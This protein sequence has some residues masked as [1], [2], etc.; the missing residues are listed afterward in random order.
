MSLNASTPWHKKSYDRFLNDSLPRLLA[1]RLP[2][3]GYRSKTAGT[4]E[5]RIV[6]TLSRPDG[7]FEA[8]YLIPQPDPSGVFEIEQGSWVVVPTASCDDLESADI[9]C[10][11]E[12]LYRAI[13]G[14]LGEAPPDFAWDEAL[15]RSW[16]PLD[17]WVRDFLKRSGQWLDRTNWLSHHTHLRRISIPGRERVITRSHFGRTCPIETP[18]GPNI[19]KILT[20]A[21]GAAIENGKLVITDPRPEATFGLTASMIPFLEYSDANRLIIGANMMRQW[22]TPEEPEPAFVRTGCEP[23]APGFWCGR[24]LL[25]AYIPWGIETYEDSIV[26]SESCAKKLT[27]PYPVEPGDKLSNRHGTKGVVSRILPDDRMPHLPDGTP[28]ELVFD[29]IAFHTRLNFGQARELLM[30]RIAHVEGK[31]AV[32]PPFQA[33]GEAELRRRL[34]ALGLPEDGMERLTLGRNGRPLERPGL[35]GYVY[36]GRLHHLVREKIHTGARDGRYQRHGQM[37]T[38]A[39][40][41]AGAY[42]TIS[43]HCNTQASGHV[44]FQTL[45]DEIARGPVALAGPPSPS[46]TTLIERLAVAGIRAEF[47]GEKIAFRFA[48]PVE[49]SLKL[50]CPVPHP[51]LP[52]HEISEVG[53]FREPAEFTALAE[54]NHRMERMMAGQAPESLKRR[55]RADLEA[56]VSAFFETL[57]TPDRLR[58]G[59]RVLFSGRSVITVGPELKITQVGLPDEI[60]WTLFAP[61]AARELGDRAAVDARSESAARAMDD[62]MAHSWV[63][64]NRAP[65]TS[66]VS[67]LAFHPVRCP[68]RAIRLHP[69]ACYFLNADFDGDQ[70]AVFLPVTETGQREAGEKLSIA[71]HLARDPG[72]ARFLHLWHSG[73]WALASLSLSEA[74]LKKIEAIVGEPVAAPDGYITRLTLGDALQAVYM[75]EG[76][77]A[78]FDRLDKLMRLGFETAKASGASIH[79]YIGAA[80]SRPPQPPTGDIEDWNRYSEALMAQLAQ[81]ADFGGIDMG[82]QLLA[83]KSGARGTLNHLIKLI[84]LMGVVQNIEG[85]PVPAPYR[86]RDGLSCEEM[87]LH[88]VGCRRGL[89]QMV[90]NLD[91]FGYPLHAR[92]ETRGYNALA[93]AMRS[94]YPGL[95]FA[96]AA[97]IG[98]VD[99]LQDPDS[100]LFVGLGVE[101]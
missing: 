93:R 4:C 34:A 28:V 83:C 74:G 33:P 91:Q 73:H 60:A 69:S 76:A 59:A 55:A 7:D 65:T 82:P 13:A 41:E 56:K 1:D 80:L 97:A 58:L 24:N 5:C 44:D 88:V 2:L 36:W 30:G 86:F 19:G 15:L 20:I 98:E 27:F 29:F 51:W 8:D 43:E 26:V 11:G 23:D 40:K 57:L 14:R 35:A 85:Q 70:V 78:F 92:T 25:T 101:R 22:V 6:L 39:L 10:V 47:D 37:E 42:I 84:G 99:H 94:R 63:I 81:S 21:L 3:T 45:A 49:P 96:R 71:G 50:A 46:L 16:L 67:L 31:T 64:I 68:D 61:F 100:R 32:V 38:D 17:A 18:E 77:E 9:L 62:A 89:A 66:A 95:V 75:R 52:E 48:P 53:L 90:D 79:P 72:L 87:L 54:A 12:Q